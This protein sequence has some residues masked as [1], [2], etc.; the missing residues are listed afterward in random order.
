MTGGTVGDRTSCR[1]TGPVPARQQLTPRCAGASSFAAADVGFLRVV[2]PA[3]SPGSKSHVS[4]P[5]SSSL[6]GFAFHAAVTSSRLSCPPEAYFGRSVSGAGMDPSLLNTRAGAFLR[7]RQ[8]I[9]NDKQRS[10][11]RRPV[12]SV[13]LRPA[14]HR[15]SIPP[16]LLLS[17]NLA[18][19]R[20]LTTAA[21]AFSLDTSM[22][23]HNACNLGCEGI[24]SK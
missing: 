19:A 7:Q 8:P 21:G 11:A 1:T 17:K 20:A 10:P 12:S 14:E 24:V 23:F 3:A 13:M 9:T 4:K 15:T 18:P 2:R 5:C 22:V 16:Y 6:R